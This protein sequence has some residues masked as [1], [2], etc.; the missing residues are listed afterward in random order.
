MLRAGKT[1]AQI[2]TERNVTLQ[3]TLQYL[4]Q[5]V[6]S[7]EIQRSDIFFAVPREIRDHLRPFLD[8]G[9]ASEHAAQVLRRRGVKIRE[10]DVTVVWRYGTARHAL[11]DM[12]ENIRSIEVGLYKLLRRVLESIYP[13]APTLWW[14]R[15][16]PVVIQ[17]ECERR[18]K[19]DTDPAGHAS[20]YL[21]ILN[22]RDVASQQWT[23]AQPYLPS[24]SKGDLLAR[25]TRLNRIRRIVMHPLNGRTPTEDDFEFV[26][27]LKRLLRF[28]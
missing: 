24:F 23:T 20:S 13:E 18:R 16:V 8:S 1:P 26:R 3:T 2:S 10:G 22:L 17:Q 11:G 4:D 25:L 6:G 15:G 21:S 19:I 9:Q 7:G 14:T 27:A 28:R 12:Y 5:M